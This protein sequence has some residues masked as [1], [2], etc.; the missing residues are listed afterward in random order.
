MH[1]K[2]LLNPV[3]IPIDYIKVTVTTQ[4]LPINWQ[5]LLKGVSSIFILISLQN[6]FPFWIKIFFSEKKS[7]NFVASI[8]FLCVCFAKHVP[9]PK[10]ESA[11]LKKKKLNKLNPW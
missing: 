5:F 8:V 3:I 2:F 7:Y 9:C 10:T 4:I 11:Y 6:L 1:H